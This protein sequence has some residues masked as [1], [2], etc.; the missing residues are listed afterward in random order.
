MNE[1]TLAILAG[2]LTLVVALVVRSLVAARGGVSPWARF[3]IVLALGLL[4]TLVGYVLAPGD[5]KGELVI[6][7]LSLTLG[8]LSGFLTGHSGTTA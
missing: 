8:L 1:L 3:G 6:S 7:G 4:L 5:E 2:V